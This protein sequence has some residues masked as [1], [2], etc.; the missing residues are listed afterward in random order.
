MTDS[1]FAKHTDLRLEINCLRCLQ[2][3]E[4]LSLKIPE[5]LTN[6]L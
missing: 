4:V 5:L 3:R 2:D 1:D 6:A